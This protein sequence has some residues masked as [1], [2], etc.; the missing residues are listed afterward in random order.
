MLDN[1]C[2]VEYYI[3]S[4]PDEECEYSY[5][6]KKLQE[7][8]N[9]IVKNQKLQGVFIPLDRYPESM[10]DSVNVIDMSLF[11]ARSLLIFENNVIELLIRAEG[12]IEY[13]SFSKC[14][15]EMKKINDYLPENFDLSDD[16]IYDISNFDI[17]YQYTNQTVKNVIVRE[18]NEW[19]FPL[20]KYD[21]ALAEIA[22]ENYD[23]PEEIDFILDNGVQIR[24]VGDYIEYYS[25]SIEKCEEGLL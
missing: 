14:N 6:A 22:A 2:K 24:F 12:M 16:Y 17:T 11:G 20:S 21:E 7:D 10:Y 8:L 3:I 5:S 15:L 19:S 18:T 25:I 4:C 23:L 13:R 9:S 1:Y